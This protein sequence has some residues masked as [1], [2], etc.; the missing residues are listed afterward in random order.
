M[1][2][3]KKLALIASVLLL[4]ATAVAKDVKILNVSYDPTRELY[5]EYN[6]AFAKYWLAKTGDK[7]TVEQSHGGSGARGRGRT[8]RVPPT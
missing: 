2:S 6:T 3:I 7:V 5:R 8:R 1:Q 4:S